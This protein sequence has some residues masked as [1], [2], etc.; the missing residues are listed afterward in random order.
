MSSVRVGSNDED[1]TAALE[2]GTSPAY[3]AHGYETA[4]SAK[5]EV[6]Q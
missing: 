6:P 3:G 5:S 2:I 1:G 4:C